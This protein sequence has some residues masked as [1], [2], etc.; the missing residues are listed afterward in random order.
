MQKKSTRPMHLN[1]LAM[2]FPLTAWVSIA[3]RL[4]GLVLFVMIPCVLW[5]LEQSLISSESFRALHCFLEDGFWPTIIFAIFLGAIAYHTVAGFRHLWMDLRR[6]TTGK[7]GSMS[8][9]LTVFIALLV[10]LGLCY[11]FLK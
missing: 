7:E 5:V 11:R 6:R 3:H 4:S 10:F 8:A 2:H 9:Q 1:V